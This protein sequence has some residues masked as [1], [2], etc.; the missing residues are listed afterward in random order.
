MARRRAPERA[1]HEW[2]RVSFQLPP[3]L[4]VALEKM[5]AA[6]GEGQGAF[7]RYLIRQELKGF[8]RKPAPPATS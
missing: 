3:Q 5:V 1:P 4:K 8:D 2:E 6:Y 7:L